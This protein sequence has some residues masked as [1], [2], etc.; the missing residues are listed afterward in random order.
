MFKRIDDRSQD[1]LG[2]TLVRKHIERLGGSIAVT[3]TQGTG[4]E[5]T[6]RLPAHV[7]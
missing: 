5:F 1:G 3:S 2:L 4:T 6:V 7:E